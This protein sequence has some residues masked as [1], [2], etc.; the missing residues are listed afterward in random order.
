MTLFDLALNNYVVCDP[1]SEDPYAERSENM[2]LRWSAFKDRAE[3]IFLL[4]FTEFHGCTKPVVDIMARCQEHVMMRDNE[5]LLFQLIRL[6]M[7]I[8]NLN[9]V[10]NKINLNPHSDQFASAIEWGQKYAKWGYP[11]SS[12]VPT[13]SGM[14]MPFFHVLMLLICTHNRLWMRSLEGPIFRVS[15]D[16]TRYTSESG[17]R[18]MFGRFS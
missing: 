2:K 4:C 12:R 10:F 14:H 16:V 1:T 18:S 13:N 11:L 6:K 5:G 3:E 15:L 8:D 9:V 7:I 17:F